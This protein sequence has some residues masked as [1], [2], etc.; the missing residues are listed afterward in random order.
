MVIIS[1]YIHI[2][3][4]YLI[5]LK[6]IQMLNVTNETSGERLLFLARLS[7]HFEPAH[8]ESL[9]TQRSV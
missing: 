9:P 7:L 1:Q 5:H 6:L 8:P 4:Y 2:S 3:N